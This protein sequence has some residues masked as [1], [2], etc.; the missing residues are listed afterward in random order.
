[1]T[2][3]LS[4]SNLVPEARQAFLDG[5]FRF[6]TACALGKLPP[7]DRSGMLAFQLAGTAS[8]DRIEA[9]GRRTRATT[10]PAVKA[11]RVKCVPPSGH[12]VVVSGG[13]VSLDDA[14]DALADAIE[15]MKRARELGY[16][17]RTF[18]AA[19]ADKARKRG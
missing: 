2:R 16:T 11:T 1:M 8:R 17:A 14:A 18:A 6:A 19:M 9:A 12:T 3:I 13:A 4:V 7:G 5:K 15:E 10:R